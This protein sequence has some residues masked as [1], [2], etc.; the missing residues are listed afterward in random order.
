VKFDES[1]KS[2]ELVNK[3]ESSKGAWIDSWTLGE[4]QTFTNGVAKDDKTKA[5]FDVNKLTL[6]GGKARALGV[7]TARVSTLKIDAGS[8]RAPSKS[9]QTA[10]IAA[11]WKSKSFLNFSFIAASSSVVL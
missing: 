1:A 11:V 10:S 3:A 2:S 9:P 8:R 4:N 7:S 5:A 6:S